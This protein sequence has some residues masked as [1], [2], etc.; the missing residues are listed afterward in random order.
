MR[1]GSVPSDDG[2][3]ILFDG[4][5]DKF[6][7]SGVVEEG[8]RSIDALPGQRH[9][10]VHLNVPYATRSGVDLH[11]HVIQSCLDLTYATW[12]EMVAERLPCIVFVQGSGWG[13][14]DMGSTMDFWVRFAHRGYVIAL[15]E[16]RPSSVAPFPAQIEDARTATRWLIEH[17]ERFCI[18][19]TRVALAGDSSGGHVALMAHATEGLGLFDETPEQPWPIAAYLDFYGPS[20][21][22]IGNQGPTT[23]DHEG[24][25]SAEG[26][27]FGGV[28]LATIPDLVQQANPTRW[29]VADR[30]LAPLL[31]M[32]GTK[33]RI[34]PLE[35]S[36]RH[37]RA[38]RAAA[39]PVELIQVR[40]GDHGALAASWTDELADIIDRFLVTAFDA[41][42][43]P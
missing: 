4:S 8:S 36:L 7:D 29:I 3:V 23:C 10:H 20:D 24:S 22:S 21:L 30:A 31:M 14:Q 34:V 42:V 26:R 16:H 19:P 13:P 2:R 39:Q 37:F 35:H 1:P 9:V 15:V 12:D 25:G 40:N 33:D 6:S 43:A 27:L 32:H 28:D 38:L 17:H 11:V 5:R 18:D 41:A